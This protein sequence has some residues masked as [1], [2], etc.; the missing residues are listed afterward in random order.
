MSEKIQC[1]Y[2][3]AAIAKNVLPADSHRVSHIIS[4][5]ASRDV[6]KPIQFWQLY[7][8]LGP[9]PI[10]TIVQSFYER[11]FADE[12]WFNTSGQNI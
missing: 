11:V 9:D 2:I 1:D 5:T 8:V 12:D 7:S 3:T 4:L 6:S 10:V